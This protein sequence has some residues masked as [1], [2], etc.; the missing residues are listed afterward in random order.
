MSQAES[1]ADLVT[2]ARAAHLTGD[3]SLKRLAIEELRERFGITIRFA[4]PKNLK[5]EV[6][7]AS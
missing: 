2:I 5:R 6:R 3:R 1:P 4:S 7:S